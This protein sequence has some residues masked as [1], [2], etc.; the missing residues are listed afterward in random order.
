MDSSKNR[1]LLVVDGSYQSLETVNYVSQVLPP[2]N[3]EVVMLHIT[4]RVPE[5][6]WDLEKDPV[7]QQKVQT[8]RSWETHQEN[9]INEFMENACQVF[10]NAGFADSAV[11]VDVRERKEGIARDI[12]AESHMGY[13]SVIIGRRGL[14]T[15]PDLALGGVA[16]KVLLRTSDLAVWLVGGRPEPEMILVGIDSSDGSMLAVEHLARVVG[17]VSKKILL[18]HVVRKVPE[19]NGLNGPEAR[20][21]QIEREKR[22]A[23][24]IEPVF[25]K[26]FAILQAAGTRPEDISTK[27]IMGATTRAGTI[28]EEARSG[29]Y[30]TIVV[31][32]RGVSTVEDFDMGRV[33]NKL[34]QIAKNRAIWVVG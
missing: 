3:S 23:N 11:K 28:L 2:D 22:A 18:L 32:R 25:R 17:S 12:R 21:F 6:F 1:F 9:R 30:G 19:M 8:V 34:V 33:G 26:S 7:W 29:G 13:A 15:I 20:Q 4:S 10:R 5:A 31:G 27:V 16:N 14:S 24:E